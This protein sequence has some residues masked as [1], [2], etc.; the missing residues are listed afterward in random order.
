MAKERNLPS[1]TTLTTSDYIRVVGSDNASYKQ[2]VTSVLALN[3]TFYDDSWKANADLN[4]FKADGV[5]WISSSPTNA[6]TG[7]TWFPLAVIAREDTVRQI[8]ISSGNAI[9][10]R[11]FQSNAWGAWVKQPTRAEI[12]ELN[13]KTTGTTTNI[14]PESVLT[15][16]GGGLGSYAE[17]YG[18]VVHF[19]SMVK[20]TDPNSALADGTVI[21]RLPSGLRPSRISLIEARQFSR[22]GG[23]VGYGYIKPDG[24]VYLSQG[25]I[26]ATSSNILFEAFYLSAQ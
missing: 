23:T 21:F 19:I 11:A 16:L 5:Y 22:T 2:L 1:K 7:L 24:E 25:G 6:P 13:S 14:N 8:V 12:D 26:S 15:I 3:G 4:N 10:T 9:H 17:K 20:L 18:Q